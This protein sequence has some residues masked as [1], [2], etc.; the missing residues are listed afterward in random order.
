VSAS[1]CC[2]GTCNTQGTCGASTCTASGGF[3][4]YSW[5]CCSNYCDTFLNYCY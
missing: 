3:C 1:D 4:Y 5:E 2:T